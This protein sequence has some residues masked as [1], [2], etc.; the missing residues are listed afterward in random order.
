MKDVREGARGFTLV[1]LLV[2]V[3][4]IAILMAI[5]LPALSLAR[6]KAR[7][8]KCMVNTRNLSQA[9]SEYTLNWDGY[10][11]VQHDDAWHANI[12]WVNELRPYLKNLEVY[13]CPSGPKAAMWDGRPFRHSTRLFTYGLNNW[14]WI[15]SLVPSD[16]KNFN[17]GIG[18][19]DVMGDAIWRKKIATIKNA[20]EM[21]AFLD[22]NCDMIWDTNVD[23]N[24]NLNTGEGPGY[25]HRMGA[26]VVFVDGHAEWFHVKYLV[27]A[28][29]TDIHTLEI[30]VPQK[31]A[32]GM[33]RMWDDDNRDNWH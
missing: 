20:A 31:E 24:I 14:G 19:I 16:V 11:V 7:S 3:A 17:K 8:T 27:G 26:N 25:R 2:V 9:L 30:I 21:I 5:L 13:W 6:E 33:E 23:P 18:S 4:I 1:E 29:Y 28:Q 22:G 15:Q 32:H 12:L 10:M